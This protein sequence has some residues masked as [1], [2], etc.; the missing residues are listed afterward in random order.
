[1]EGGIHKPESTEFRDLLYLTSKQPFILRLA[2]SA[3]I[4]GLL[5]G[6]DTGPS[7]YIS[8]S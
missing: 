8:F 1:M 6:Y 4:G 3:G 5:F 2:F 7:N